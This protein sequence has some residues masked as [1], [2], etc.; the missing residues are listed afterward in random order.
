MLLT[1]LFMIGQIVVQPQQVT[2]P[3]T[4]VTYQPT[5]VTV[6][7]PVTTVTYQTTTVYPVVNYPVYPIY[8]VYPVYPIYPVNPYSPV[9]IWRR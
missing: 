8:P 3:V 7:K 5:T 6:Y 2:V 9:I 4:T 1:A